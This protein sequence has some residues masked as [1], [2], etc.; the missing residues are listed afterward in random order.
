MSKE[1]EFRDWFAYKLEDAEVE[2]K[3]IICKAMTKKVIIATH[4]V[5]KR[6]VMGACCNTEC[7]DKYKVKYNV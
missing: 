3:C 1:L 2:R 5:F 4:V 7:F 6:M